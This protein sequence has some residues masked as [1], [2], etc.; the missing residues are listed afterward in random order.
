MASGSN[1]KTCVKTMRTTRF[2]S[3]LAGTTILLAGCQESDIVKPKDIWHEGEDIAFRA[4]AGFEN[5]GSGDTRTVYSG[6]TYTIGGKTYE[7]VDWVEGDQI[8]IYCEQAQ[9]PAEGSGIHYAD[10][11]I[12]KHENQGSKEDYGYLERV[13]EK[14]SLQWGSTSPEHKF[15]ALYP[16]PNQ[17][18][19]ARVE[20]NVVTGVIP[21]AQTPLSIVSDGNGNHV[22]KPNMDYAYMTASAT[23]EPGTTNEVSLSFQSIATAVEIELQGPHS[24]TV[25]L[26]DIRISSETENISGPFTC[27]LSQ[28]ASDGYPA[29]SLVNT[30]DDRHTVNVSLVDK[31][32]KAFALTSG[33]TLT[34]TVFLLPIQDLSNLKI[35]LQTAGGIKSHDLKNGTTPMVMKAHMKNLIKNIQVP[36]N[37]KADQWLSHVNDG[38]LLSQLSIPGSGNS[39]SYMY[40][41]T[42]ADTAY[43]KA[44][45]LGLEA[46]WNL[47]IR[48]FEITTGRNAD[49]NVSNFGKGKLRIS[50]TGTIANTVEEATNAVYG[51]LEKSPNE[52]ALMIISYQPHDS[53]DA[54]QFVT[55]F[56]N[57]YDNL[58]IHT[59]GH[60]ALYKPGLTIGDVRGKMM[61]ILRPTSEDEDELSDA[62]RSA[63]ANKDFLV[64]EGWGSLQD[65]WK[66]R[67]YPVASQK[68]IDWTSVDVWN[69]TM[70]KTMFATSTSSL[71][72]PAFPAA[73]AKGEMS[74]SYSTNQSFAAWVQEW[75]RVVEKDLTK[76]LVS[77]TS[78][79]L[80]V[81]WR[82]SYN[83]KLT[84]A[85]ATFD[86]SVADKDNQTSVYINSLCGYF[87]D[88]NNA[89]T[90]KPVATTSGLTPSYHGWGVTYGNIITFS[91]K[92]NDDFYRYVLSK[93]SD[94]G[95][96]SGP[97]GVVMINR[98]G[99]TDASTLMPNVI[100]SN[101]F[102][103]PLLTK[104]S[105]TGGQTD[106]NTYQ[107]G[108]SVI[109]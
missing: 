41:G 45:A 87:V 49:S 80:W 36:A 34:L 13:N 9:N 50:N 78:N 10:Y 21:M 37:F 86:K 25:N 96:L 99:T 57:W 12:V 24:Q 106:G 48:C 29:C 73:L 42:A 100:I 103:F 67:G 75:P 70:E 47:G 8:R 19:Q 38:V 69:G 3:A 46:Q 109:K 35:S 6:E 101:N 92:I 33:H 17:Y 58:D 105:A 30:S 62:T 98:V 20:G 93:A 66:K 32:G 11:K 54:N 81:K 61:F 104:D 84:D 74:Y 95:S 51:M 53:R 90:Y 23:M 63:I 88:E 64:V 15:Y 56:M 77:T 72:A 16:S 83:E 39:Y 76:V 108:G 27:D 59:G 52:F 1:W 4:R 102:K 79:S 71:V 31:D 2:L 85:K 5:E 18:S 28:T 40:S 97:V 107:N 44:Q 60:T 26:T 14:G 89:E 65:K 22:A 68:G 91:E 82:E 94:K 55:D 43:Y 7:R